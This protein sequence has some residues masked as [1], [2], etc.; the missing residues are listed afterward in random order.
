MHNKNSTNNPLVKIYGIYKGSVKYINNIEKLNEIELFFLI[1]NLN[2]YIWRCHRETY[3]KQMDD[4]DFTEDIY[5][6][7]YLKY[8]TT[9]FGVKLK[10]PNVFN[11]I[12][13][14]TSYESWYQ[15]YN[16]YFYDTLTSQELDELKKDYYAGKDITKYLP[17]NTWQNQNKQKIIHIS[18]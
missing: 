5:A 9:R 16:N 2:Y 8:Q 14:S 10:E 18:K 17:T 11:K 6:L 12:G 4:H 13:T 1:H 15:F 3:L 7:E